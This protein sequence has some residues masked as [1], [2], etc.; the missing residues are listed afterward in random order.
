MAPNN[1]HSRRMRCPAGRDRTKPPIIDRLHAD[2]MQQVH[3]AP[4][5]C[6]C[7]KTSLHDGLW[8][9]FVWQQ[10]KRTLTPSWLTTPSIGHGE[11]SRTYIVLS[12]AFS[13]RALRIQPGSRELLP[14][15]GFSVD[16][17]CVQRHC[18]TALPLVELAPHALRSSYST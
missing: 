5:W 14:P 11:L 2:S 18:S 12:Q 17:A 16:P 1:H 13:R 6:H 10:V 8:L 15:I 7:L 4:S 9:P 3:T